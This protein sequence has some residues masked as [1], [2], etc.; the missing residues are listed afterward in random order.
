VTGPG[1]RFS[2]RPAQPAWGER[3]GAYFEYVGRTAITVVGAATG[4]RYQFAAPGAVVVVDPRDR[5]SVA[6]VPGLRQVAP[7]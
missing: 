5:R 3:S 7:R 4:R 1:S 2:P 6:Q